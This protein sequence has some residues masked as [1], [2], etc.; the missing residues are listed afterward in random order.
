MCRFSVVRLFTIANFG[1]F[2]QK[3]T[4][5]EAESLQ[6]HKMC[7]L[8]LKLS[9]KRYKNNQIQVMIHSQGLRSWSENLQICF[10]DHKLSS[11]YFMYFT[12]KDQK[13]HDLA[14]IPVQ[15]PL[16]RLIEFGFNIRRNGVLSGNVMLLFLPQ[17]DLWGHRRS[18]WQTTDCSQPAFPIKCSRNWSAIKTQIGSNLLSIILKKELNADAKQPSNLKPR[19]SW[20]ASISDVTWRPALKLPCHFDMCASVTLRP[21]LFHRH[22]SPSVPGPRYTQDIDSV[23][24]WYACLCVCVCPEMNSAA[25]VAARC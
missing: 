25:V 24:K 21:P 1:K 13:D 18:V 22:C 15:E 14:R 12:L 11:P 20:T 10:Q 23:D 17:D 19:H 9:A 2:P 8:F 3:A 5:D 16:A 7:N 4:M 6:R